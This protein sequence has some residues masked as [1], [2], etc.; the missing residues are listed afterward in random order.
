MG[1]FERIGR[2]LPPRNIHSAGD[3][4]RLRHSIVR[5]WRGWPLNYPT[6]LSVL[7][8]GG[9]RPFTRQRF[10]YRPRQVALRV[11]GGGA[12]PVR[13]LAA[14]SCQSVGK[15]RGRWN[16]GK[17]SAFALP[18]AEGRPRM[19]R[20]VAGC[21]TRSACCRCCWRSRWRRCGRGACGGLEI[22]WVY[23]LQM[24]RCS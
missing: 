18:P 1:E 7:G 11:S 15:R 6:S 17:G 8:E 21:S 24:E 5:W 19:T 14:L 23:R 2:K 20:C 4:P 13:L 16:D 9:G 10:R 12:P 3:S 22:L